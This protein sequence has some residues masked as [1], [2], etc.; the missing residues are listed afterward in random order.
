MHPIELRSNNSAGVAPEIMS[1]LAAANV[2]SALAYG[3]DDHTAQL[4]D[5]VRE[6]F[7]HPAAEVFP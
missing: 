3:G 6:V 5:L 7:Q 4:R 1:A 2:G